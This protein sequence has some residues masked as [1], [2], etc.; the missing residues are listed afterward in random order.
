LRPGKSAP[1]IRSEREK[2]YNVQGWLERYAAA[3][4]QEPVAPAERGSV[5]QLARDVAH[6]VER[7]LAPLSTYL[8]GVYVGRAMAESEKRAGAL[9]RAVEA[10]RTLIPE[11][12][13]EGTGHRRDESGRSEGSLATGESSAPV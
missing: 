8:A 4:G 12:S 7:K 10:A 1:D 2:G 9:E 13:E 5:L 3:L 11:E 6:G